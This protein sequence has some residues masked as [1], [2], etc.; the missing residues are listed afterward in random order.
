MKYELTDETKEFEGRTLHRIR[1]LKDF[2]KWPPYIHKGDLGG[3]VESEFNLSQEGD[4]WIG[5]NSIVFDNARVYD[6]AVVYGRS[7]ICN[8]VRIFHEARVHESHCDDS[9]WIYGNARVYDSYCSGNSLIYGHTMLC[10]AK[11][12]DFAR[13]NGS[14]HINNSTVCDY[15]QITGNALVDCYS[16]IK[17]NSI[18]DDIGSVFRGIVS[19]NARVSQ[20]QTVVTSGC[21]TDLTKDLSESIRAQTGLIPFNGQVIAYKQVRKNLTSFFDDDFQYKVGEWAIEENAEDSTDSCAPGLHFSNAGYWNKAIDIITESTFIIARINLEDII[22]VQDG[23]IRCRK[24]FI[25]GTYD[26]KN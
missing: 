17:G 5:D 18:I 3:F 22:T 24:A 1:A 23:K 10:S 21:A 15:A 19:H 26:I 25:L 6:D 2:R 4:C 12:R 20:N 8:D 9:A 13:I 7:S 16:I 14:S 11:V